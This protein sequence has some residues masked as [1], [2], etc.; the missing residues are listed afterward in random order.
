VKHFDW[1]DAKNAKLRTERGIRFEDVVFH[2]E[3]G[4]LLDIL[5]G[6]RRLRCSGKRGTNPVLPPA[7]QRLTHVRTV[8]RA[9]PKWRL[10]GLRPSCARTAPHL[11]AVSLGV[12]IAR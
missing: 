11:V 6:T 12:D 4:D 3:H 1:D 10:A 9:S 8:R 5:S 2:I 7:F